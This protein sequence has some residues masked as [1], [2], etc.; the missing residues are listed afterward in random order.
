MHNFHPIYS[1]FIE[2]DQVQNCVQFMDRHA[3]EASSSEKLK[4]KASIL[5][6]QAQMN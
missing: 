5:Q 2:I 6:L 4:I 3:T 1:H